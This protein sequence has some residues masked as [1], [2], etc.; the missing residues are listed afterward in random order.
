MAMAALQIEKLRALE[1]EI[2]QPYH[3][4]LCENGVQDYGL[5]QCQNDHHLSL[6]WVLA[7]M[8][9]VFAIVDF[10]GETEGLVDALTSRTE[11]IMANHNIG[12]LLS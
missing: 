1:A 2:L 4:T 7:R 3:A 9:A 12:E 5:K 6:V 8:I 11:A 10:S